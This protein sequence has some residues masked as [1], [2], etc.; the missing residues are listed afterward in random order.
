MYMDV[1]NQVQKVVTEH[2]MQIGVG[3]LVAVLIAGVAWYWMAR[4]SPAKGES[5]VL[6]NQARMSEADMN[7]M[8]PPS[9]AGPEPGAPQTM[10][11]EEIDRQRALFAEQHAQM[12]AQ[13]QQG[14]KEE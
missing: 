8:V 7:T 3:L 9:A 13:N 2:A 12:L 14:Q 6:E 5:K 4:S 11:A 1:F 10:S